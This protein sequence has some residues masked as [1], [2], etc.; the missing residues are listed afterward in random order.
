VENLTY[1]ADWQRGWGNGGGGGPKLV[2]R[3]QSRELSKIPTT[4]DLLSCYRFFRDY[5]RTSSRMRGRRTRESCSRILKELGH[6][7]ILTFEKNLAAWCTL[8]R[9]HSLLVVFLQENTTRNTRFRLR[10]IACYDLI[11]FFVFLLIFHRFFF[12]I[13][14]LQSF[15]LDSD[16]AFERTA[17]R[18]TKTAMDMKFASEQISKEFKWYIKLTGHSLS[19]I[20]F[21]RD[22]LSKYKSF[23][24]KYI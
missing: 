12:H 6:A 7:A 1:L 22:L 9:V 19:R 16:S 15:F 11:S 17:C 8:H 21:A 5:Y 24:D 13:F 4:V 3:L 18:Q 2:L 14:N 23:C 20:Q 10:H